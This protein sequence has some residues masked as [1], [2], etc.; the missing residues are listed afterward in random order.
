MA[1]ISVV[2]QCRFRNVSHSSNLG[3]LRQVI[4][5]KQEL[6]PKSSATSGYITDRQDDLRQNDGYERNRKR[7]KQ[8]D[9]ASRWSFSHWTLRQKKKR[10]ATAAANDFLQERIC[11]LHIWN[12]QHWWECLATWCSGLMQAI[13]PDV[14]EQCRALVQQYVAK[15]TCGRCN[16]FFKAWKGVLG[17]GMLQSV[18]QFLHIPSTHMHKSHYLP[19]CVLYMGVSTGEYYS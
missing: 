3:E 19:W 17:E 7:R 1:L 9:D 12:S 15:G 14:L 11:L 16:C 13:T 4:E 6:R 5:C 10:T 8:S 18:A 2:H